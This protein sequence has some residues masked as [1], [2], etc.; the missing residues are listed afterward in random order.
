MFLIGPLRANESPEDRPGHRAVASSRRIP[1]IENEARGLFVTRERRVEF[2]DEVFVPQGIVQP[3]AADVLRQRAG[4]QAPFARDELI[5]RRQVYRGGNPSRP[6]PYPALFIVAAGQHGP[7]RPRTDSVVDRFERPAD[8]LLCRFF[9]RDV[10]DRQDF[11]AG[12]HAGALR[13]RSGPD[14]SNER[15][16]LLPFGPDVRA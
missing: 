15:L 9:D 2:G 16:P 3:D 5:A 4:G 8:S 7:E 13:V 1:K 11:A 12:S 10:I 14:L 6:E